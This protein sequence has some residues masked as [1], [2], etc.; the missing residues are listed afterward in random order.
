MSAAFDG[1]I[2][3]NRTLWD[4]WTAI[5]TTGDFYDVQRYYDSRNVG[6]AGPSFG[7]APVPDQYTLSEFRRR[8]LSPPDRP[9]RYPRSCHCYCRQN[10]CR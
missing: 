1:E 5:H 4:A 9:H 7:Y 2:A 6:Y 3:D 10:L 8:E